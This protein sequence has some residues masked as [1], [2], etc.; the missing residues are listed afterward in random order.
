MTVLTPPGY[1][2]GGTYT[3][4]LDRVYVAT[5]G[6]IANLSASFSARQGFFGGRVPAFANPSAMNITMGACG[7]VV[8]NTFASASGDYLMAN[9][10]TVQVTLAASSP[11]QNRHDIIGFQVKDNLFDSSGLNT[12]VPAV[13]QGSNSAGTPSDPPLPASFIPVLRAV[14]NATNTSPFAL[15]SL[16]RKTAAD[17]GLVKIANVTERAELAGYDGLAIYREDRDWVEIYDGSAWRVQGVAVCASTADR[18]TAITNPYTGQL[19]ITTDT[20]HLWTYDGATSQWRYAVPGTVIGGKVRTTNAGATS[21][22]TELQVVDTGTLPLIG[23]SWFKIDTFLSAATS[24]PGDDYDVRIVDNAIGGTQR[25]EL[26]TP[27]TDN[28]VP[29]NY[30]ATRMYLTTSPETK[31]FAST[32]QRITGTGV[33]TVQATSYMILTYMGA[34]TMFGTL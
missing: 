29:Y 10:A 24:A 19:S 34:A 8:A 9:D 14:V 28:A 23:N 20:D 26:V 4:K 17:G 21:G 30:Q 27:R 2:Q 13:I 5:L 12:A 15:Q 7:A 22:S 25:Q 32:I 11:T 1:V 31:G 18:T 3:A 16:I 33:A 6:N